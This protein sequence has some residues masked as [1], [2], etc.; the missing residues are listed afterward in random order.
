MRIEIY[1][2]DG[3]KVDT[4]KTPNEDAATHI[5]SMIDPDVI[6]VHLHPDVAQA[7]ADATMTHPGMTM[8]QTKAIIALKRHLRVA[9]GSQ[10]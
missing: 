7:I 8:K 2:D 6:T 9:L 4:L 10:E 1:N 5:R 3:E